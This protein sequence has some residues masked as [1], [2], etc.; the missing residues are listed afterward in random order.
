MLHRDG[1]ATLRA[2]AG[3]SDLAPLVAERR[4]HQ[5]AARRGGQI[6]AGE[7]RPGDRLPTEQR[8]AEAHGVSRTVVREA[9]H[10]LRSRGLVRSRQGS[11]VFVTTPPSG[12]ALTLD[13]A[14][15]GSIEDV[16]RVREVRRALEAESAALAAERATRAQIAGL[17]RALRA[18]DRSSAERR[19]GVEEDMAFH[20]LLAEAAGNPHFARLLEFLEQYTK[21]AMRV[22]R[23][24]DATRAEFVEAVRIEH[25]A[26]VDAIA[27]GDAALARRRAVQHM[28]RGD[29]RMRHAEPIV[30][31]KR[32]PR[33]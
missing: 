27:A 19:D 6:D 33:R 31:A 21:E 15:I 26:I 14:L 10:Q 5:L 8:L 20:R 22:T 13:L 25:A 16:L 2:P 24:N 28:C 11:G 18:I 29:R 17:R 12:E 9:V 32:S 1:A 3:A 23:R 4:S 30:A 7:L